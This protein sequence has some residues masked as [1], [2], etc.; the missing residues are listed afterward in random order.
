MQKTEGS[1]S[2]CHKS[3]CLRNMALVHIQVRGKR[4]RGSVRGAPYS[5]GVQIGSPISTFE[6]AAESL[7]D[8]WTLLI[9]REFT[10]GSPLSFTELLKAIGGIATNILSDRLRMLVSLGILALTPSVSDGRKLEYSLSS[11]GSALEPVLA[12]LD[13]WASKYCSPSERD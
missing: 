5:R 6:R 10:R 9:A 3:A 8:S 4:I 2:L 11:K 13:A 12:E 1:L 7:G